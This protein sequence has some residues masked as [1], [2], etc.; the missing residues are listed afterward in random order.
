VATDARLPD[1]LIARLRGRAEDPKR[2]ADVVVSRFVQ[3]VRA[4]DLGSM[5][6]QLSQLSGL[7]QRTVEANRAARIDPDGH[8][9]ATQIAADMRTPASPEL[10]QRATEELLAAA[11]S[12]LGFG[13]PVGLRQ[14]LAEVADGGFGPGAGLFGADRIA[15]AYARVV[16]DGPDT[17]G[18]EWPAGL[19]PVV[20]R[21]PGFDCVEAPTGRV[22][23]WD[24]EDLRERSSGRSWQ[25]SF[26][27][28]AP[29][30][31]AWLGA[32]V[33]SQTL[34]ERMAERMQSSM[35]E[36]ARE[37]RAR[38]RAMSPDERRAMGLP[39]VGWERVVWG[40]LGWNEETGE[41]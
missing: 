34:E 1:D 36:Q 38:I 5:M 29:S 4:L 37:A 20:D 28:I 7:L 9:R 41:G 8:A 24:P 18:H 30:V 33:A 12:R 2:R 32:W 25:R 19:L 10:P 40:G 15:D 6:G 16:R 11:E 13:F 17:W 23:N 35:L 22:V 21:D 39:D 31:E 3:Q 27:E 26:S 14:V